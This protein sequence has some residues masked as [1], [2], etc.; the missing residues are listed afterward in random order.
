MEKTLKAFACYSEIILYENI[1]EFENAICEAS[2][3]N[4]INL[5]KIV[6]RG[7]IF[8]RAGA[9]RVF[10]TKAVE[11][12][13]EYLRK[14]YKHPNQIN[15]QEFW[16]KF[17]E[18]LKNAKIGVNERN[19]PL[20]PNED[21]VSV[22]NIDF[23]EIVKGLNDEKGIR[24][25][26]EQLTKLRGV[27]HKVATL[28]LRDLVVVKK[29]NFAEEKIQ[30]DEKDVYWRLQPVDTWVRFIAEQLGINPATPKKISEVCL[31]AKVNPL[32]FNAGAWYFG[33][34]VIGDKNRIREILSEKN[35][36]ERAKKILKVLPDQVKKLKS[37]IE[38]IFGE[39][40]LREI[41]NV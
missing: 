1:E 39:E 6:L 20:N 37:K 24:N 38:S 31:D 11:L 14:G 16:E 27:K 21:G 4:T 32:R 2:K 8:E 5:L 15:A 29:T 12:L 30:Q 33:A 40:M 25:A 35:D 3:G 26:Y 23:Q 41:E 18:S 9:P 36:G 7:Y 28:L 10:R 13:E 17:K 19:N 34:R 22:L